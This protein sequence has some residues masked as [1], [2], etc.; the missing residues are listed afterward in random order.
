VLIFKYY[1]VIGLPNY[2]GPLACLGGV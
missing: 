2:Y 1:F